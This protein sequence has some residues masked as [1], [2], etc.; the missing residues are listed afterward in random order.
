MTDELKNTVEKLISMLSTEQLQKDIIEIDNNA[1]NKTIIKFLEDVGTV[2][3][4]YEIKSDFRPGKI[5]EVGGSTNLWYKKTDGNWII[6]L[7]EINRL[8]K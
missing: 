7:W 8:K 4:N 5:Q 3:I 1:E 6:K 2:Q